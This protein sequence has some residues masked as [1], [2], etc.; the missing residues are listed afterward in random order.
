MNALPG[1]ITVVIAL[2]IPGFGAAP[3][4]G[5]NGYIEAN[6]LY[7]AAAGTGRIT[8]IAVAEGAQVAA[9]QLLFRLEDSAQQA[10]LRAAQ[11]QVA[12]AGANL[13]NLRT[14]GRV[15]EIA[16]IR[17]ALQRASAEQQLA[18]SSLDRA[19]ALME[20]GN[21]TQAQ[22][23]TR[24]AALDTASAQMAQLQAELAVAEL[25]ARD[26]Q[27]LAAEA[28]LDAARAEADRAAVA[29]TDRR[30]TAAAAGV[31]E[32]IFFDPGEVAATGAP[33]LSLLVEGRLT[34][35]F[36]VPEAERARFRIGEAFRVGCDSCATDLTARLTR[37]AD[38][39][40]YTPPIIYS[41]DERS[42]LV[43]RAEAVLDPGTGLMPGQP[44]TVRRNQ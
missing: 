20:T 14:G 21:A 19:L 34:V 27:Q 43:Y 2:L 30:V 33:V 5:Y 3:E 26:A 10:A 16:V 17:A 37:L 25:P 12:V 22:I 11:A 39:P 13:E 38:S 24:R 15:Q 23:D 36:F 42:R 40:Q 31:V 6:Y 7:V 9:G 32:R 28:T 4:A 18:Q 41:R 29:L 8:E 44:V 35:L 1:W